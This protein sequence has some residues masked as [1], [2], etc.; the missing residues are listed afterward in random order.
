MNTS[1]L[2]TILVGVLVVGAV[3]GYF[4]GNS[5]GRADL[6]AEQK[7]AVKASIESAQAEIAEQ[8]NPF[9]E[10]NVNPFED[11]YENPFGVVNPFSQ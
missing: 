11:G 6:L 8:A 2:F 4:Y 5:K 1:K 10:A 7:A 9:A 3:A